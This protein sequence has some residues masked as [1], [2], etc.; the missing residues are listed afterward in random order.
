MT[1]PLRPSCAAL[2]SDALGDT[3]ESWMV[4]EQTGRLPA[5]VTGAG[6][7]TGGR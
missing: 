5:K 1:S 6:S 7:V 3:K 4:S 2:G